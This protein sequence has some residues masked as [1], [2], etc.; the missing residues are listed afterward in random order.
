MG[1]S[2]KFNMKMRENDGKT[3]KM[4]MRSA[5]DILMETYSMRI[6]QS[7]QSNVVCQF[8]NPPSPPAESII[9]G[10]TWRGQS[11][12][13]FSHCSVQMLVQLLVLVQY[14]YN[15]STAERIIMGIASA[16]QCNHA[17][18]Q[19][20]FLL[21]NPPALRPPFSSCLL[22]LLLPL[23]PLLYLL[24]LLSLSHQVSIVVWM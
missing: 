20:F 12:N 24:L 11:S 16:G 17:V 1:R 15:T 13:S 5:W 19:S 3:I 23:L 4:M 14:A 7:G 8:N 18:C 2:I 22:Y 6:I 21:H 10:L 9:I